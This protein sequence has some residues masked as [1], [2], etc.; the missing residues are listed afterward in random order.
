MVAAAGLVAVLLMLSVWPAF[1]VVVAVVALVAVLA[2]VAP[3][4]A[5]VVAVLLFG[6]EGSLKIALLVGET[7]LPVSSQVVGAAAID[8][9]FAIAVAGLVLDAG[10]SGLTA[11]WGN[12]GRIGRIATVLLAAWVA[13][14]AVQILQGGDVRAGLI[15][16]RTTQWYAF[17]AVAG[18][19]LARRFSRREDVVT[20]LVAALGIVAA[21]GALR[22]IIGPSGLERTHALSGHGVSELQGHI[23]RGV[24]SFSGAVGMV[25]F[26]VPAAIFS[27]ALALLVPGRRWLPTAILA[28]AVVAIAGSYVRAGLVALTAGLLVVLALSLR[29]A[30]VAKR[31]RALALVVVA[32]CLGAAVVATAVASTVSPYIQERATGMLDPLE[33]RA[34]QDR[35]ATWR[36]AAEATW[37]RPLGKGLGTV[38]RGTTLTGEPP[39]T[40]DNSYFKVFLEQGLPG[41]ILFLAAVI[42]ACAAAVPNVGRLSPGARSVAIG[43]VAAFVS[44]LVIAIAGEYVEQPGKVLAWTFIG[45]AAA[46]AASPPSRSVEGQ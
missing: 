32:A 8:V 23:F 3:A 36:D 17:A 10:S 44:F 19:L 30:I 38:G 33:D 11:V 16:F 35:L 27:F 5:F 1:T 14:S 34:V 42:A 4:Y 28:A 31:R 45:M 22:T 43:G 12:F 21:Y 39:V 13:L 9:A 24:G 37:E 46:A 40:T 15:G 41:G 25:S 7:P 18:A 26:L 20:A 6:I 2:W 29:Y